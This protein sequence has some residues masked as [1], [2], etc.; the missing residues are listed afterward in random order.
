MRRGCLSIAANFGVDPVAV[1]GIGEVVL[2]WSDPA[3]DGS[4]TVVPGHSF[5]ILRTTG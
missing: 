2:A 4:C 3:V 1:P 5:A